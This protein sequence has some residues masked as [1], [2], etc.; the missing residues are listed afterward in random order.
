MQEERKRKEQRGRWGQR[1]DR[2]IE[3]YKM[4]GLDLICIV[5]KLLDLICVVLYLYVDVYYFEYNCYEMKYKYL[6]I[7]EECKRYFQFLF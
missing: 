3:I 6:I 5:L 4:K 2:E 1:R 7:I